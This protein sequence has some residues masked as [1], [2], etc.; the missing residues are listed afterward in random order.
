MVVLVVVASSKKVDEG[1]IRYS[2]LYPVIRD[3]PSFSGVL[4]KRST[5][6]GELAWASRF[7]GS[8]GT[9]AL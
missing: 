4:Q 5:L 3:P 6:L 1:D 8:S 7:V 9:L 2:I